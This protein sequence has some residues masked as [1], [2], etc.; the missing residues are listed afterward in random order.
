LGYDARFVG[1]TSG[2]AE[3]TLEQARI[4]SGQYSAE[5]MTESFA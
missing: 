5:E 3:K 1:D 4:T 2:Q